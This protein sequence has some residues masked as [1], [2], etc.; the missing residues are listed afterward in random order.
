MASFTITANGTTAGQALT[1]STIAAFFGGVIGKAKT[2]LEA[3]PDGTNWASVLS[4]KDFAATGKDS[5]ATGVAQ[6]VLP[7]GW[8][9]RC[10]TVDADATTNILVV[11]S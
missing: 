9:V 7:P 10:V 6:C 3:S 11:V 1:Q 5:G 2:K 8:Q 4:T